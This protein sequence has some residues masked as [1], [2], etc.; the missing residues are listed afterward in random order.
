[1]VVIFVEHDGR[2]TRIT[3]APVLLTQPRYEV[4]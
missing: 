1:M 4:R 3:K 2:V